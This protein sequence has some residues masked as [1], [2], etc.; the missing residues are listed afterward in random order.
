MARWGGELSTTVMTN[1]GVRV[2]RA[3]LLDYQRMAKAR[4]S[5]VA[6]MCREFLDRE[7]AKEKNAGAA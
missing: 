4:K 3:K 1:I 2:E 7:L 5:S 6:A